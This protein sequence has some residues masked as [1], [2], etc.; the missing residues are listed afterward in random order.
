[1][2]PLEAA[3]QQVATRSMSEAAQD[4]TAWEEIK[5]SNRVTD[6][7]RYLKEFPSGMFVRLAE[8]QMRALIE[9]QTNPTAASEAFAETQDRDQQC[10][11]HR[12]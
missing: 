5:F 7:Q 4:S 1:L 2:K 11:V 6:F 8:N 10:E 9:R 3:P 12:G